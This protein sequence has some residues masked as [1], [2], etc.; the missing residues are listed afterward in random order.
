MESKNELLL[1][2]LHFAD[3]RYAW[4]CYL[5]A[6]DYGGMNANTKS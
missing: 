3:F 5:L 6:F 4:D 1:C 2:L